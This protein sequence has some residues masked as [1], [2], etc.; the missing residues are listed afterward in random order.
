MANFTDQAGKLLR[1][2]NYSPDL[3]CQENQT[4]RTFGEFSPNS[5]I[6]Y[7]VGVPNYLLPLKGVSRPGVDNW[8]HGDHM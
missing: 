5:Q 6:Q 2:Q 3:R 8:Q 4:V 1:K 7:S